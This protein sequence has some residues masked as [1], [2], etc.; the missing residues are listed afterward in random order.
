MKRTH[1]GDGNAIGR[2]QR[3]KSETEAVAKRDPK[4]SPL[5]TTQRQ[6]ASSASRSNGMCGNPRP[7]SSTMRAL[8][9]ILCGILPSATSRSSVVR[10]L[11][12]TCRHASMFRMPP[13]N[14][15]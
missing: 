7:D 3:S 12:L 10:S 9:T 2:P 15:I 13:L 5:G 4:C 6:M 8:A 14:L 11:G 1:P